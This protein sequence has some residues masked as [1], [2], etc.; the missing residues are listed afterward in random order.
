MERSISC[1]AERMRKKDV[2]FQGG[3]CCTEVSVREVWL[4]FSDDAGAFRVETIVLLVVLKKLVLFLHGLDRAFKSFRI[5]DLWTTIDFYLQRGISYLTKLG[6]C[7]QV[8]Q[9]RIG[10]DL[11]HSSL[12]KLLTIVSSVKLNEQTKQSN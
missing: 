3:C 1:M 5:A 12:G 8:K 11:F 7:T 6:K 10:R 4:C 9:N 2:Y